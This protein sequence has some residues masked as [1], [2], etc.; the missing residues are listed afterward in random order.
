LDC[1]CFY[2]VAANFETT[3]A[4]KVSDQLIDELNPVDLIVIGTP[5]YNHGM[6]AAL[7]LD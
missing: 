3:E 7:R 4:I 6:P 5:M 1:C 2:C